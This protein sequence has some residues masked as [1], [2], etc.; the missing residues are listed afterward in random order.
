MITRYGTHNVVPDELH[1]MVRI[2]DVLTTNLTKG[3]KHNGTSIKKDT[4]RTLLIAISPYI[5]DF[6]SFL[7][8]GTQT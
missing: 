2:T 4:L 7:N 8:T 5:T 6:R 3:I 1:L